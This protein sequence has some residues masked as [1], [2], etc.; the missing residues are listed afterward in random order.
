MG[1]RPPSRIPAPSK[2]I[3]LGRASRGQLWWRRNSVGGGPHGG[4][5]RLGVQDVEQA[6]SMS[7][8]SVTAAV[9]TMKVVIGSRV[10]AIPVVALAQVTGEEAVAGSQWPASLQYSGG[11]GR[12]LRWRAG[13][14]CPPDDRGRGAC[15][16]SQVA[17]TRFRCPGLRI[18]G[19]LHE[20]AGCQMLRLGSQECAEQG[21]EVLAAE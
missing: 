21:P 17:G 10:T 5:A 13:R 20:P 2:I 7:G 8:R 11:N 18:S 6:A 4:Q 12:R 16:V 3:A 1:S 19:K 9:R 14:F 15:V